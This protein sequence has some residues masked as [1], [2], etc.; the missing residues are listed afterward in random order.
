[1]HDVSII[2]NGKYPSEYNLLILR[3]YNIL[4]STIPSR[5]KKNIYH[6]NSPLNS[7]ASYTHM[8]KRQCKTD[9]NSTRWYTDTMVS[10]GVKCRE[11]IGEV[12]GRETGWIGLKSSGKLLWTE[13]P[14][15]E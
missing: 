13:G 9:V 14:D 11:G 12:K 1:M 4:T 3:T 7:L 6:K 8:C 10:E 2:I 15:Y 5:E